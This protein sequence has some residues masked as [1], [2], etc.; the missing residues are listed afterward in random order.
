MF[1]ELL[2][3]VVCDGFISITYVFIMKSAYFPHVY[4]LCYVLLYS[5]LW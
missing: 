1:M 4:A 5:T 2:L 3:A